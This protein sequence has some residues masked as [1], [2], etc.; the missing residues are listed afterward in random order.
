MRNYLAL[1][2]VAGMASSA[3]ASDPVR[4]AAKNKFKPILHFK[5]VDEDSKGNIFALPGA[6][7]PGR[8]IFV[9]RP[10]YLIDSQ[11]LSTILFPE[12]T[13]ATLMRGWVNDLIAPSKP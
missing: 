10:K 6:E 13:L 1:L 11:L 4:L 8:F 3:L 2:L 7:I 9:K 5:F 12:S